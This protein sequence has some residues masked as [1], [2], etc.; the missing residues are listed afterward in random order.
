MGCGRSSRV[1][2]LQPSVKELPNGWGAKT[3][4]NND[5]SQRAAG[6]TLRDGSTGSKG[7]LD[8]EVKLEDVLSGGNSPGE[9]PEKNNG[10][11]TDIVLLSGGFVNKPMHLQ[12]QERQ[13]SSDILEELMMQGI[14]KSQSTTFRNG[15][16]DAKSEALEKTL[17]KPPAKLEKLKIEKKEVNALTMKDIKNSAEERRKTKEEQP[18]ERLQ[19]GKLFPAIAHQNIAELNEE[20]YST[21]EGQEGT[22]IVQPLSFDLETETLL[23]K[24]EIAVEIVNSNLEHFGAV[25]SDTTYNISLNEAF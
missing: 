3:Q 11:N 8:S 6:S 15:E 25:E 4:A 10:Q 20:G 13:K 19:S 14:I 7:I 16:A 18:K 1:E 5:P 17:K 2:V 21:S 24:E 22:N 12:E 23:E 9:G